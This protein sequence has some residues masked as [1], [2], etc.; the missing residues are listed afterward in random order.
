[1][2]KTKPKTVDEIFSKID[3]DKKEIAERLRALVK[4]TLPKAVESVR[5]GRITYALNGKDLAAIR[6]TKDHVDVIFVQGNRLSSSLMKGQGT[7]S[8]PMHVEMVSLKSLTEAE[9]I[10]LLKDAAAIT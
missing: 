10:R 4:G 8:D 2:V 5:Q 7:V 1:M 6:L 3:P 9:V